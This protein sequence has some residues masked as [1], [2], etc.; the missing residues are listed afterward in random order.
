MQ[1]KLV[2]RVLK[3]SLMLFFFREI[4]FS[5]NLCRKYLKFNKLFGTVYLQIKRE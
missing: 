2:N 4:A 5:Y 3:N 1:L